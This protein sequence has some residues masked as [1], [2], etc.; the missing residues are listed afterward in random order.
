MKE[1]PKCH[2]QYDDSM[3]FCI[4]DGQKLVEVV[5]PP[6][7]PLNDQTT[8]QPNDQP[9]KEC[10]KCHKQYDANMKFCTVDGQKLVDVVAPAPQP[11]PKPA[12]QP[13]AP[14]A[15]PPPKPAP[16]PKPA[17]Q[18]APQ[19][20]APVAAPVAKPAPAPKPPKPKK[21]VDPK[22]KRRNKRL[23][24]LSVILLLLAGAAV[25]AYF[26]ITTA[27]TY[28][29]ATPTQ[30]TMGKS[31]GTAKVTIDYDGYLW[32]I[33]N[34]PEW[35]EAT[36]DGNEMTLTVRPNSG[37]TS[38]VGSVSLV[39]GKVATS[40]EVSQTGLVTYITPSVLSL[41]LDRSGKEQTFTVDTDGG[42]ITFECP[43]FLTAEYH[44]GTVTVKATA[45]EGNYRNGTLVI[46]EDNIRATLMVEQRGACPTCQG[47]GKV[48]CVS[49]KG[50]GRFTYGRSRINCVG[51]NGTGKA[52][53]DEC[54]GTGEIGQ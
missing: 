50:T 5:A 52:D 30:I 31:G 2:K 28:L 18:P 12:S 24:I 45:N 53:C 23:I 29:K 7:K 38:R 27:T 9:K 34:S 26:F 20:A 16:A 44:N 35:L 14:V 49:C 54:N 33:D 11:A 22:K 36:K 51:C 40:V 19:P 3:K 46:K 21:P 4:V 8:K 13:A 39:S 43:D 32:S 48:E 42:G 37:G 25:G 41:T 1:C 10:P 15:P 47:T 17:P 6:P